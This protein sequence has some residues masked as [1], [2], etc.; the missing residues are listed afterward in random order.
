MA[1]Y[2]FTIVDSFL[3]DINR[4]DCFDSQDMNGTDK[5]FRI[6]LASECPSTFNQCIDDYG[7][8]ND[9]VALINTTGVDDGLVSMLWSK[10]INAERTATVNTTS[11]M[12]NFGDDVSQIKAMFLVS[13]GNG[14]GYVLAYSINNK[15]LDIPA[16]KQVILQIQDLL[17][18]F[19]YGE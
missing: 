17:V 16:N 18:N 7:T 11:T 3:D 2:E 19:R 13:Y 8:L 10:G 15:G 9:D 5:N 4:E 1:D 12:F 14:S 6:V